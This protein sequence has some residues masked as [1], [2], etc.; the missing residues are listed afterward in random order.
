MVA[1]VLAQ[2][3]AGAGSVNRALVLLSVPTSGLLHAW[4][5]GARIGAR[6]SAT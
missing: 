6:A 5:R 2:L 3:A 1:E 4:K